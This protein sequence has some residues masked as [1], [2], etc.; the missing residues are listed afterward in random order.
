MDYAINVILTGMVG[1]VVT[2]FAVILLSW[3]VMVLFKSATLGICFGIDAFEE[4]KLKK[5]EK[6]SHGR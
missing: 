6:D 4:T 2:V 5:K 1:V 3:I